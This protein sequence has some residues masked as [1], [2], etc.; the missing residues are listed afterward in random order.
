MALTAHNLADDYGAGDWRRWTA[1]AIVAGGALA[2]LGPFGSY[3]NGGLTARALYWIGAM[4]VGVPLYGFAVVLA[5]AA[6]RPG[7]RRWW[8]TLLGATLLVSVPQALVTRF[9]AHRLWPMLEAVGPSLPLWY[10]QTLAIGLVAVGAGA[11]LGRRSHP[12]PTADRPPPSRGASPSLL[13]DVLALQMEDHYVRVHREGGSELLLMPLGRAVERV[14][15]VGLRTHRSWWVARHAVRAVEG[16]ARSMRLRLSNGLVAP[17]A[18][19]AVTHLKAAGWLD[20]R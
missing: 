17:V 5:G 16:D 11:L 19:S 15:P 2:I 8:P 18:R 9:A 6:A 20:P 3:L 12:A 13:G 7:S 14:Q 4:L 1:A 10:A